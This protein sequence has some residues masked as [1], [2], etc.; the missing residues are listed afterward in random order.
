MQLVFVAGAPGV[1]GIVP[2]KRKVRMSY[3]YQ[4]LYKVR[5]NTYTYLFMQCNDTM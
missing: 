3:R 2:A 4:Y 1:Y 5:V